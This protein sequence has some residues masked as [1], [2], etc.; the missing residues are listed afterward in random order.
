LTTNE[1][2]QTKNQQTP[3]TQLHVEEILRQFLVS[4]YFRTEM[5]IGSNWYHNQKSKSKFGTQS[6]AQPGVQTKRKKKK[7]AVSLVRCCIHLQKG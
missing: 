6:E 5:M 7:M 1:N 2:K 4:K 3:Q